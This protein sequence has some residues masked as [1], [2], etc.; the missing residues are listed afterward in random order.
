[1]PDIKRFLASAFETILVPAPTEVESV[2]LQGP[3]DALVLDLEFGPG[4]T[5]AGLQ[6]LPKMRQL[7]G[8]GVIIALTRSSLPA[9]REKALELGADHAF[10]APVDFE[11]L[12]SV[13]RQA[14]DKRAHERERLQQELAGRYSF[15]EMIGASEAMR[16]VYDAISRVA[17]SNTTVVIRGESGTGKE[18]VARA[19]MQ[20]SPRKNHPF[21]SLNCA[22]LPENLIEAELFGYEKGAFTGAHAARG[23]H[24]EAA[25]QGTLFLDEIATLGLGLQSKLLRVLEDHAVQRLG[26]KTSKKIDFRLV[27]A[28]NE[29]LEQ[30]LEAGRF[31]EDLYY[32]IHVVPILLPPLRER[33]GDVA[34]LANHFLRHYCASNDLPLKHLD[35]DVMEILEDSPWP[36]NVR[37]LENLMQ[38]LVLMAPGAVISAK[39]LPKQIVYQ[40]AAKQQSLL[41]PEEGIDF[42]D[43]LVRIER[44]YLEAALRRTQGKKSAAAG[45]LRIPPQKMKYLCRKHS[46]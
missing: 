39:H 4:E 3:L 5:L 33:E 20:L 28:T 7:L 1:L 31:R 8:D 15:C 38:R 18:L 14:M 19:I 11:H 12:R 36:G 21:V 24:I 45:L 26:S 2:L 43:E 27:T 6:A 40:S 44:A 17:Q 25:H 22:A 41:I 9:A 32:R 13:L 23:G 42:E 16:L 34:L 35:A 10:A 30:M 29:N 46:L 37:E